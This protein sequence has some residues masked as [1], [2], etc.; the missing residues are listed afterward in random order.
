MSLFLENIRKNKIK[1]PNQMGFSNDNWFLEYTKCR[2]EDHCFEDEQVFLAGMTIYP[3]LNNIREELDDL[4]KLYNPFDNYTDILKSYIALSNRDRTI[5]KK[6]ILQ[7]TTDVDTQAFSIFSLTVNNHGN[8]L[9][10]DDIATGCVDGMFYAI[11]FCMKNIQANKKLLVSGNPYSKLSFLKKEAYLSQIYHT[12]DTLWKAIVWSEYDFS[13]VE[14]NVYKI[15]QPM[16][17]YQQSIIQSDQRKMKLQLQ[18]LALLDNKGIMNI[19]HTRMSKQKYLKKSKSFGEEIFQN[20]PDTIQVNNKLWM[21]DVTRLGNYFSYE[22]LNYLYKDK[23]SIMDLL[24]VF[25]H[26]SLLAYQ[27]DG[28]Y[29]D[30]YIN[31]NDVKKLHSFCPI[32]KKDKLIKG[33]ARVTTYKF[34]EIQEMLNFLE[35]T[36]ERLQDL[37][38]NPIMSIS[39]TEYILL[40]SALMTPN[41]MRLVEQW[42]AQFEIDLSGKGFKYEETVI[43]EF[44]GIIRNNDLLESYDE[45]ISRKI[46]IHSNGEEEIDL[47]CRIGNKILL[48]ELKSIVTVDSHISEYRAFER[49][50]YASEQVKRKG[51]F[52][53]RN[54]RKIFEQLNWTYE[55]QIEYEIVGFILNSEKSFAGY[56]IDDI[57]VCDGNILNAYFRDSIS[58][59]FSEVVDNEVKHLAKFILYNDF[60]E[61]QQNLQIYLGNPPQL[62]VL[63]TKLKKNNIQ[64]PALKEQEK[65]ILYTKLI[66]ESFEPKELLEK[67]FLFEIQKSSDYDDKIDNFK[68][69]I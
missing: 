9:T 38:A 5:L 65:F 10:M 4:Y 40:T 2:E 23:F 47:L 19:L 18:G 28:D 35:Y 26:I 61:L 6:N 25:K 63:S 12:Y 49:L 20:A 36:A 34:Q 69:V 54:L 8:E 33:I 39:K 24:T 53:K 51:A 7:K 67:E 62:S 16:N 37:W 50:K 60:Q 64:I 27:Y 29:E 14:E 43:K 22:M 46:K 48:G 13:K 66:S 55:S 57:P 58:P 68:M 30:E 41:V 56:K 45:A 11:F 52:V 17:E 3:L 32:V 21:I 44:N 15:S 42:F 59:I 1:Q 31:E